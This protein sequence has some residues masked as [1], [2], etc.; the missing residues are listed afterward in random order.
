MLAIV[1][2]GP[3][4]APARLFGL[5]PAL[6]GT[7]VAIADCLKASARSVVGAD[8][9]RGRLAI[10]K[11]LIA[12]QMAVAVLL[13]L[14]AAL[15]VRS[16]EALLRVDVGYAR[17]RVLIARIDPRSSGYTVAERPAMYARLFE[18]VGRLPGVASVSASTTLFSGRNRGAFA[19]EGYDPPPGEAMTTFKNWVTA[20]Y[21]RTVG[22]SITRG[23]GFGP[24]DTIDGRPVAVVSEA[25]ARRYFPSQEPIGRR[26]TWG[27]NAFA[28]DGI[29]IVGVVGDARYNNVKDE[30]LNMVYLH[31]PQSERFA[32]NVQVRVAGDPIALAG[33]VRKAIGD[34][35]PRL[36]VGTI[37]TLDARIARSI[38]VERLLGWLTTAFGGAALAL[39]CLGL[40]GTIANA[41]RRRTAELGIRIAL[42]ADRA[43][44]RW[45]IVREALVLV[46]AGA[47]AGLSLA[48]VSARALGGLLYGIAPSD[49]LAYG[50]AAGVLLL[51]CACAAYVP[52][53]RASR[54]D[55][56]AAL[57]GE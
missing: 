39:A 51:V 13:L 34:A 16:L 52:A 25:V 33:A 6:R 46:L 28:S 45:L 18:A 26:L 41:V 35:E 19:A 2:C 37:E 38:G 3:S 43:A 10:G 44:I 23:R 12:G 17:G 30:S 11:I 40:Y 57:R 15:F 27:G 49:P 56:V 55:P 4:P 24:G 32:E 8:G 53:W 21:F 1:A 5:L 7:R 50:S 36:A 29:E 14:V 20:D 48:F 54:L 47:A 9:R 22:L 31:V 42:G